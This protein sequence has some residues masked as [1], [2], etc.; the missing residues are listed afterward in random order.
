MAVSLFSLLAEEK[1]GE[2]RRNARSVAPRDRVFRVTRFFVGV[3]ETR[4]TAK[5][6]KEKLTDVKQKENT[7]RRECDRPMDGVLFLFF[8]LPGLSNKFVWHE[9]KPRPNSLP[10]DASTGP[11]VRLTRWQ[12]G[13]S[14][15]A[16]LPRHLVCPRLGLVMS[17]GARRDER[18][19]QVRTALLFAKSVRVAEFFRISRRLSS[20][21]YIS[22]S[23]R[24]CKM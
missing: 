3:T 24:S 14:L 8:S 15:G 10:R 16:P 18:G 7:K 5:H 22:I 13:F 21:K 1:K 12:R 11:G 9:H 20:R 2:N 23:L 4:D 19:N 6:H 17:R